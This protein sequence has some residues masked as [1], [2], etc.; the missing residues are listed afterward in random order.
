MFGRRRKKPEGDLVAALLARCKGF[1][2]HVPGGRVGTVEE[3][4][5]GE[6]RRWDRPEGIAVRTGPEGKKL[7]VVPADAVEDVLVPEQTI[8]VRQSALG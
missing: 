1:A 8:V 6:S 2:V 4:V 7:V 5:W 3:I